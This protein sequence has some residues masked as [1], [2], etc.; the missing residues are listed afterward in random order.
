MKWALT[1]TEIFCCE[2]NQVMDVLANTR[3]DNDFT[4]LNILFSILDKPAP[5]NPI[6]CGFFDVILQ[7]LSKVCASQ[8]LTW[9][10]LFGGSALVTKIAKHFGNKSICDIFIRLL[11]FTDG[12]RQFCEIL[13]DLE[14][15]VAERAGYSDSSHFYHSDTK[16][17]K[18]LFC[19]Q[20][21]ARVIPKSPLFTSLLH[22]Y[23]FIY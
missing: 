8:L 7:N 10:H 19:E 22:L 13:A 16:S 3:G 9:L 21:K 23:I 20:M 4:Y 11:Q 17:C 15:L 2:I 14:H 1:A 12:G 18:L 5:L 6:Q